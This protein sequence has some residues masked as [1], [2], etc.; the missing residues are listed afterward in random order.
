[1][2]DG[3][4]V[5]DL[6][7]DFVGRDGVKDMRDVVQRFVRQVSVPLMLDSTQVDVLEEGL[8]HAGGKCILNSMNLEEGEEKLAR[9]CGLARTYGAAVVAGT[10]DDDPTEAMAKTAARKLAIAKRI[11]ALAVD[12]YGIHPG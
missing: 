12:K 10:I 2:K 9:I 4:H 1:V 6:C 8:K 3:S 5:L 11:Y 7:V